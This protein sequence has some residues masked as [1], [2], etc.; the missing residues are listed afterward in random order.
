MKHI[1]DYDGQNRIWR[2]GCTVHRFLTGSPT[3]ADC[4]KDRGLTN[5]IYFWVMRC[6]HGD[7][8][9]YTEE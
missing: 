3:M 5:Y 4:D 7:P 1:D 2:A 8:D 6:M 9:T